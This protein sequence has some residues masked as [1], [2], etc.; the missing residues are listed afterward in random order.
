MRASSGN[1]NEEFGR[2][3]DDIASRNRFGRGDRLGTANLIDDRARQRAAEALVDGICVSLARPITEAVEGEDAADRVLSSSLVTLSF[4]I[5]GATDSR[6]QATRST[7]PRWRL[8]LRHR[9]LVMAQHVGWL[10]MTFLSLRGI[11]S[12]DSLVGT[13]IRLSAY[14]SSSRPSGRYWSTTVTLDRLSIDSA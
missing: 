11:S 5:W 2:W 4:S 8:A 3:L 6:E 10:S 1:A 12:M 7:L 13:R 9:E 14:I